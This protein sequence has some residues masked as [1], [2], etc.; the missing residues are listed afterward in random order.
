MSHPFI[1]HPSGQLDLLPP[2]PE[3]WD[4]S[5]RS[6]FVSCPRQW[7]YGY[8]LSLRKAASSVHLHFGGA[9]AHGLE[10]ARKAFW[11]HGKDEVHA[12]AAGLQALITFWGD[13]EL[14]N[15]QKLSISTKFKD[16]SA[17]LDALYS[18][19][20]YFP[21]G[22]DQITPLQINGTYLIEKSFALPVP[23][24]IHPI[25]QQ[26]I[27][28]A[29]RFDMIGEHDGA[30]FIVDEKTSRSLGQAW[31]SNWPLRGQLTGYTWGARAFGINP[32]GVI[33]RGVASM[34]AGVQFQQLILHRPPWLVDRWLAQLRKDINR[35]AGMWQ[36][37]TYYRQDAPHEPFDQAFD[38]ACSS[39]GG[40][41]YLSLC[42]SPDPRNWYESFM[43]NKWDPLQR[44]GD[45]P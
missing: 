22:S 28:Y 23:G 19:F 34:A 38:S 24:T 3:V 14:T 16:L 30:I 33:I 27:V 12:V 37:A 31:Q 40:C 45:I 10:A 41:G 43:V 29:G 36:E 44:A 8:L 6:A 32:D 35:A 13:F 4:S 20:E 21:L 1:D 15:E 25:T 11:V 18:Y 17:C 39:F 26:P 2:F 42:D 7:Y 5:M 9:L